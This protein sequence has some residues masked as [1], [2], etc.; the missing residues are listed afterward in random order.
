MT[1]GFISFKYLRALTVYKQHDK[2]Q[3]GERKFPCW[4]SDTSILKKMFPAPSKKNRTY[5]SR[6]LARFYV[7]ENTIVNV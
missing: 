7:K 3:T 2:N 5:S 6:I 4:I 1:G